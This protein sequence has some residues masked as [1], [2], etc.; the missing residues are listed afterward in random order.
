MGHAKEILLFFNFNV[1]VLGIK[2]EHD[3]KI[4]IEKLIRVLL[5]IHF[6]KSS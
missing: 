2:E 5:K 6:S 1:Q 3:W 4:V